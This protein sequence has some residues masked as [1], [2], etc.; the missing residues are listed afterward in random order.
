MGKLL[1]IESITAEELEIL[2]QKAVENG[3]VKVGEQKSSIEEQEETLLNINEVATLFGRTVATI[4]TYKRRG[5][6]PYKKLGR[7]LF[8]S[9]ENVLSAMKDIQNPSI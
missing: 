7:S 9:K 1:Q 8:F 2:I 5:L 4:H 6:I 3:L